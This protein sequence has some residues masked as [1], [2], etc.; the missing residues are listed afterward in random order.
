[1]VGHREH[2]DRVER[3]NPSF[4]GILGIVAAE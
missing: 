2:A 3:F 1:M 4:Y